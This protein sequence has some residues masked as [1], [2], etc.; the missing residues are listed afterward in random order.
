[1]R[2]GL[3]GGYASTRLVFDGSRNVDL[4]QGAVS[5][6][7]DRRFSPELGLAVSAGATLGGTLQAGD[8]KYTQHPGPVLAFGASYRLVD[9]AKQPLFVLL[10]ATLSGSTST[11]EGGGARERYSAFDARGSIVAGK[12]FAGLLSPYAVARAFGGPVFWR[13]DGA[14]VTGTDKY[15]YQLGLGLS[16]TLPAHLDLFVEVAPLGETRASAGIGLAL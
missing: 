5:L 8:Q 10:G 11:T 14:S 3:N 4:K 2:L 7:L 12:T 9:P 13:L 1:M 16:V 6:S 15:H